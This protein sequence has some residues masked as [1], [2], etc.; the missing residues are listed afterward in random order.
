MEENLSA[1]VIEFAERNKID[2]YF[3]NAVIKTAAELKKE[4]DFANPLFPSMVLS[5]VCKAQKQSIADDVAEMM[6]NN[7][8]LS[9]E[10]DL[11]ATKS[12]IERMPAHIRSRFSGRHKRLE[13]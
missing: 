10:Y 11:P 5:K 2:G 7:K 12:D 9:E 1:T 13:N 4:I 8:D 3:V 6:D